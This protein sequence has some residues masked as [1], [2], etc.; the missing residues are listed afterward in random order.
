[1]LFGM[2]PGLAGNHQVIKHQHVVQVEATAAAGQLLGAGTSVYTCRHSQSAQPAQ[3]SKHAGIS[4]S[5]GLS[6]D[7]GMLNCLTHLLHL[8]ILPAWFKHTSQGAA[9]ETT[10][11]KEAPDSIQLDMRPHHALH[12]HWCWHAAVAAAAVGNTA[13]WRSVRRWGW[14]G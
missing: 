5:G 14:W 13:G 2:M 3:L 12:A 8:P 11:H 4:C 7:T 1:M 10:Y 9:E 6:R